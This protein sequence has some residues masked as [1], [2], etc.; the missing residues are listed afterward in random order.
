MVEAQPAAVL[1]PFDHASLESVRKPYRHA[2]TFRT[3][4]T[5]KLTISIRPGAHALP[6]RQQPGTADHQHHH[7][8][9]VF[10]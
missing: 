5:W 6:P 3:Q 1:Y 9:V 4:E 2:Y 8:R 7:F 10:M